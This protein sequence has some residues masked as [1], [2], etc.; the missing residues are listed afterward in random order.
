MF[1]TDAIV[2]ILVYTDASSW[3]AISRASKQMSALCRGSPPYIVNAWGYRVYDH[4]PN[5]HEYL[6]EKRFFEIFILVTTNPSS[7]LPIED[8]HHR[9]LLDLC[10]EKQYYNFADWLVSKGFK[11]G[12]NAETM[13]VCIRKH[14]I[15]GASILLSCGIPVDRFRSRDDGLNVLTCSVLYGS[16]ALVDMFLLHGVSVPDG[17][18]IQAVLAR[19]S[20]RALIDIVFLLVDKGGCDVNS[21]SI[22][23]VPVLQIA[24]SNS[25]FALPLIDLLI[26]RGADVNAT[27]GA[28]GGGHT[29]LDVAERKRKRNCYDALLKHGA[30]HSL[31]HGVETGDVGVI[32]GYFSDNTPIPSHYLNHLLCIAAAM[33]RTESVRVLIESKTITNINTVCARNDISPLHLAAC[34]GN[35]SVCKLLLR[36]GINVS[37]KAMG[38]MDIHIYASNIAGASL[39]FNPAEFGPNGSLLPPPVRLKT[40]AELAREAGYDKLAKHLDLAMV[41]TVIARAESVDS[42]SSESGLGSPNIGR[43]NHSTFMPARASIGLNGL[44]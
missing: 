38:G 25:P 17:I 2:D 6:H 36:A 16:A 10:V 32:H 18:L 15:R 8:E 20:D 44:D 24:I 7:F 27:D 35:S 40:A 42:W 13:F 41:E 3:S 39:W 21:R 9:S 4:L 1:R 43:G 26:S 34:R 19:H 22:T 14:D 5:L 23:D 11:S 29:A 33:G 37:A 30:V 12:V 28:E 31:L